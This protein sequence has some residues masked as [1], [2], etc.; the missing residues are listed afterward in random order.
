MAPTHLAGNHKDD[1]VEELHAD[2]DE[3][4]LDR[5]GVKLLVS[6]HDAYHPRNTQRHRCD[7]ALRFREIP[8][9]RLQ[10]TVCVQHVAVQ[11]L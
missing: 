10:I 8:Q 4:C 6:A 5:F 11:D 7:A 2:K 9:T 3:F 1:S